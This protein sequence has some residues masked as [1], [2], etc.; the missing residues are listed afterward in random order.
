MLSAGLRQ[1]RAPPG[2][3]FR[4]PGGRSLGAK[5]QKVSKKSR[6]SLEKV[7]RPRG[8]KSPK[9]VS[10]QVRKVS[11]KSE[12]MGFWRLFG[13]FSRLFWTFGTPGPGGPGR[14]F[15]DFLETFWLL[16]PRLLL[17]GPR[18]LKPPR[19]HKVKWLVYK[20]IQLSHSRPGFGY[21]DRP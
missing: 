16:A 15:R 3:W 12:K 7:S 11:K 21:P 2:L 8:P 17:P 5:S 19:L 6:K 14:L 13:P 20:C 1:S 4:G 18:N 10:K 9:K